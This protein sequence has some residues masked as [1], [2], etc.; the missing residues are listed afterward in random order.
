MDT[1]LKVGDLEEIT[2][3]TIYGKAS[4]Y[5]RVISVLPNNA[6]AFVA[7]DKVFV[8]RKHTD[9]VNWEMSNPIDLLELQILKHEQ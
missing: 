5:A 9:M 4:F 3:P 1:T 6:Y 8:A 7:Q 2:V